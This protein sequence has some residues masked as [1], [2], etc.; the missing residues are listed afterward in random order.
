MNIANV[1]NTLKK[2]LALVPFLM[3]A[4]LGGLF[5]GLLVKGCSKP[6]P[7]QVQIDL[8]P[9]ENELTRIRAQQDSISSVLPTYDESL[10]ELSKRYG[11]P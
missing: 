5:S 6:E 10:R 7:V 3:A 9:Y 1:L 4:T 11:K 8:N 2:I